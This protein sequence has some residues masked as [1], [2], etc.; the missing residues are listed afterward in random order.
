MFKQI[1]IYCPICGYPMI[2]INHI[3]Y[4]G[5][6]GS[7]EPYLECI[8]NCDLESIINIKYVNN[9]NKL[10]DISKKDSYARN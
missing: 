9:S 3:E 7:N 5:D 8:N 10:V 6:L 4:D 2:K 1:P